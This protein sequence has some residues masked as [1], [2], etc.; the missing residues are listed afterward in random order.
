MKKITFGIITLLL[1]SFVF[2]SCLKN[3]TNATATINYVGR[4]DSIK[5]ANEADTVWTKN[6][7]EALQKMNV[8]YYTFNVS[9]T[10]TSSLQEYA[11]QGCNYKAGA[12][13]D[14]KLKSVK[15]SDIK[16]NIYSLHADS[17]NKLGYVGADAV[18]IGKFTLH[19]SLWSFLTSTEI[20]YY[21]NVIE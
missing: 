13:L 14:K 1:S 8:L 9:D 17:L 21:K 5:Y 3:D 2:T 20:F 11:V 6:V 10:A 7:A 12:I 15:L 19:S 4:V 18:P 16:K